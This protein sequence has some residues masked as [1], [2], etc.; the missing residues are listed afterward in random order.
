MLQVTGSMGSC[1]SKMI[2]NSFYRGLQDVVSITA[3]QHVTSVG[4]KNVYRVFTG[5][6]HSWVVVDDVIPVRTNYRPPS[7][8]ANLTNSQ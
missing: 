1:K 4:D 8:V 7:P 6:N 5:G 3:Y 2:N